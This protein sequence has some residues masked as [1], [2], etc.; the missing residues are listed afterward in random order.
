MAKQPRG[1]GLAGVRRASLTECC[2]HQTGKTGGNQGEADNR[3]WA[4]GAV[5]SLVLRGL[6]HHL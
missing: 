4:G 1:L 6:R 2:G 5:G 3:P